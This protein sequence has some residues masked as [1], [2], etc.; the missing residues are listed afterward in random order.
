[1]RF[2]VTVRGELLRSIW[3]TQGKKAQAHAASRGRVR[4]RR[5]ISN[6]D[7]RFSTDSAQSQE[8]YLF[9][10]EALSKDRNQHR[11]S[12]LR[13]TKKVTC[14]GFHGLRRFLLLITNR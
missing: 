13:S 5:Y 4:W 2:S 6:I 7:S 8:C 14:L 1:M 10:G 12:R 3:N 11:H 9:L